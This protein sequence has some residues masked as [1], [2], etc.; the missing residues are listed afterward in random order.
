MDEHV[1][2]VMTLVLNP[3]VNVANTPMRVRPVH[4]TI[5]LL[6]L[7]VCDSFKLVERVPR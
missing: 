7:L 4:L 6:N 2:C 5:V 3:P 1:F